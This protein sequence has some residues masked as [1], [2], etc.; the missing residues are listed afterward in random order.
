MAWEENG[1]LFAGKR[2]SPVSGSGEHTIGPKKESCSQDGT[3]VHWILYS[4]T[5]LI[6]DTLN[7]GHNRKIFHLD[8][9]QC[10]PNR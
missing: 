3:K 1:V 5:H 7:K 4:R 8:S 10:Q 9:I 2:G 6:T